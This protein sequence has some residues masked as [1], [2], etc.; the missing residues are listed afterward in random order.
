MFNLFFDVVKLS[1]EGPS[2]SADEDSY[3]VAVNR[4]VGDCT[5]SLR[6][7]TTSAARGFRVRYLLFHNIPRPPLYRLIRT[8][9]MVGGGRGARIVHTFIPI[10]GFTLLFVVIAPNTRFCLAVITLAHAKLHYADKRPPRMDS[11]G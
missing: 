10:A 6:Q 11:W 1:E 9:G 8:A 3:R 7:T 5:H 2:R 4:S